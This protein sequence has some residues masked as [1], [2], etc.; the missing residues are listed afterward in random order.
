[1]LQMFRIDDEIVE[2]LIK[3]AK[4]YEAYDFNL[5]VAEIGWEDWM[6]EFT[7]AEDGD[8]ISEKESEEIDKILKQIFESAHPNTE[9][10]AIEK[11]DDDE[12]QFA[13]EDYYESCLRTGH[14]DMEECARYFCKENDHM[15]VDEDEVLEILRRID[16]LK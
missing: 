4:K 12:L 15:E 13:L 6:N 8:P 11:W 9:S 2:K 3:E 14:Y 5:F 1:M 7:D 16:E 10:N